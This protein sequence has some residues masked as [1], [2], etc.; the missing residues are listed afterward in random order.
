MTFEQES[1]VS[2][3][4]YDKYFL[5]FSHF[6]FVLNKLQNKRNSVNICH[7]CHRHHAITSTYYALF[8]HYIIILLPKRG[9][10]E[11]RDNVNG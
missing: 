1:S 4:Q 9:Y 10:Y 11:I 2:I 7:I 3:V 5:R 8:Y 6:A